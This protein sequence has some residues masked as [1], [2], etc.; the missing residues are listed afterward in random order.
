M[1][2]PPNGE[3][4]RTP[5]AMT[6]PEERWEG[7]QVTYDHASSAA[8]PTPFSAVQR[9]LLLPLCPLS[10]SPRTPEA[11]YRRK[12]QQR[13]SRF[14][15]YPTGEGSG[16]SSGRRGADPFHTVEARPPCP[17]RVGQPDLRKRQPR[18][19]RSRSRPWL[20]C[21][22]PRR[23]RLE[24]AQAPASVSPWIRGCPADRRQP[25]DADGSTPVGAP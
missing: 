3:W 11:V 22:R 19:S 6:G 4:L 17:S 5:P 9:A 8:G 10:P 14:G 1:I 24:P 2:A 20:A 21:R 18:R 25:A 16:P 13:I 15:G 7:Q 23:G 12:L